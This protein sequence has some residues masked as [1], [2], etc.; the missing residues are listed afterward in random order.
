MAHYKHLLYTNTSSNNV[1]SLSSAAL[2]DWWEAVESCDSTSFALP[3]ISTDCAWFARDADVD[4]FVVSC[5]FEEASIIIST[6]PCWLNDGLT[7]VSVSKSEALRFSGDDDRCGRSAAPPMIARC[8]NGS[9]G[10]WP[11]LFWSFAAF[12]NSGLDRSPALSPS[13]DKPA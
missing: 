9:R 7:S 11:L 1:P 5:G 8:A 12:R 2:V 6:S 10:D 3:N 4:M 13:M